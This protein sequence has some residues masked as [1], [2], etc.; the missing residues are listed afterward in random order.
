MDGAQEVFRQLARMPG[1]AAEL[2]PYREMLLANVVMVGEIPAPTFGEEARVGFIKQRFTECGLQSCSSDE[3]GNGMGIMPGT[4][5]DKTIVVSAHADTPFAANDNHS[6]TIEPG[7]IS[8]PGVADNSLG[9]AVLATLPTVLE[10]LGIKLQSDLLLLAPTR[11]LEQGDQQGIRFFLSNSTIPI[12]TG[13]VVEGCPLGRLHYRSMASLGGMI[14]CHVDRKLCRLSAIEI[15]NSLIS[16]LRQIELCP[17]TNTALVLGSIR[18]GA[19]YKLPARTAHLRFQLRS[20]ADDKVN[21]INRQIL[22]MLDEAAKTKGVSAYLEVIA[23]TRSG[24][25]DGSHPLV[26]AARKIMHSIGVQAKALIYSSTISPYLEHDI[27]AVCLGVSNGDNLNYADEYIEIE[28]MLTGLAQIIG[29]LL[30][31][32]GGDCA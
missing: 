32:D 19:T 18:G 22:N 7:I 6:F 21:A 16:Q 30:C 11:S 13:I 24:G 23:R 12:T 17:Q 27:P 31:I 4:R 26:I 28:P 29:L 1:L 10:G 20:D 15:L 9:L 14:S 2:E 8:G 5:G 3:V 25:L